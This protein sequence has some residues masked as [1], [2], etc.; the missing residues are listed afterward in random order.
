MSIH[1]MSI[2][3]YFILFFLALLFRTTLAAYESARGWWGWI[4]ATTAGLQHSH[5]NLDWICICYL[6]YG[7]WQCPILNILRK[8]RD[9][10]HILM[11][12][13]WVNPLIHNRNSILLLIFDVILSRQLYF[14]L[15]PLQQ[16]TL[17]HLLELDILVLGEDFIRY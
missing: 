12:T 13:S 10:T 1:S 14:S 11:D 4:G 6:H 15:L 2:A 5:R 17:S 9:G 16:S 3:A 7:S 8:T